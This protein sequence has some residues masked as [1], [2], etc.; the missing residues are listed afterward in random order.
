MKQQSHEKSSPRDSSLRF[1]NRAP[2]SEQKCDELEST[3]AGVRTSG[4]TTFS[5]SWYYYFFY[6]GFPDG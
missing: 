6:R 4:S 2:K 1:A 3:I 5:V